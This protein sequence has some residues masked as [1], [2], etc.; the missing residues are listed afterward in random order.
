MKELELYIHIPFC[1]K[2]CNYCDFLSAPADEKSQSAYMEC[3][4]KEI[5]LHGKRLGVRSIST[6][7]FGGGTP[8]M[9]KAEYI[10][11]FMQ[12]IRRH[13]S[14]KKDAEITIECNPG[15]LTKEKLEIYKSCG[16]NRLSIGLQSADDEELKVLGRIHTY[17]QFVE[18]FKQARACGFEN[19]NIDLMHGLPGQ[20]V[21]KFQKTLEQ[22][23]ALNPEHISAYSLIIEEGTPFFDWYE[24]DLC[25]QEEGKATKV[26]PDEE[27]VYRICKFSQKYLEKHGYKR[28]EISNFAKEGMECQHNIGY[29]QRTEYLGIGL[30]A[31][32]LLE[33]VRYRNVSDLQTYLENN[34]QK[35]AALGVEDIEVLTC[36]ACMEEYMFLGLRMVSGVSKSIFQQEFCTTM[37]S[38]YG[39]VLEK[40]EKEKLLVNG[41]KSVYLTDKGM[42]VSNYVLA[43]FLIE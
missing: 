22:I 7:F 15:T 14:V 34:L 29:W 18:N 40:L 25:R 8:S 35:G 16:I 12:E 2:K 30:G 41:L 3:L 24:D 1:V 31:S 28:Y 26:L 13:F 32:S 43:Q 11:E 19:I 37:E 42:D 5:A 33:N 4:K 20:T 21:E 6:I 10:Q 9:V 27:T 38:V 23:V 17:S 36:S 39:D